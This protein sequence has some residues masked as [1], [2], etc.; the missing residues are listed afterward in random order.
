MQLSHLQRHIKGV[1]EGK[2]ANVKRELLDF[3][4]WGKLILRF[5][6]CVV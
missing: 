6:T 2:V 1:I 3:V 4:S 5:S